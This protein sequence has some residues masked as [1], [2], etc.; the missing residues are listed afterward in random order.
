MSELPIAQCRLDTAGMRAQA[1]RY[2]R[3]GAT[4]THVERE[5]AALVATFGSDLDEQLLDDAIAVEKDCCPFF[6]FSYE[7]TDRRLS[8]TVERPDQ[9]PALDALEFA[10]RPA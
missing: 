6:V 10:L 2:R 1:D 4:A 7:P 9:A 3:L 5:G 8:I